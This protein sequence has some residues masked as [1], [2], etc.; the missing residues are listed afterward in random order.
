MIDHFQGITAEK[1]KMTDNKE[2]VVLFLD[3]YNDEG[4][5]AQLMMLLSDAI[6]LRDMLVE[7]VEKAKLLCDPGQ[8]HRRLELHYPLAEKDGGEA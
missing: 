1:D 5:R 2:G 4:Q 6:G 7:E 3:Y 8:V